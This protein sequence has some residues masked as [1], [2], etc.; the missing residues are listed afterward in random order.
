MTVDRYAAAEAAAERA[1]Q[2]RARRQPLLL[3]AL[4]NVLV[5]AVAATVVVDLRRLATPQGTG[6]AW[7]QAAVFGDCV[8]YLKLSEPDPA[9]PDRRT[10]QEICEDL[11]QATRTARTEVARIGLRPV[12]RDV[13]G[14]SAVVRVRLTRPEGDVTVQLDLRRSH[15]R[16]RVVRDATTCASVGCA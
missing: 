7:T 13:R 4:L 11:N 1:R 9:L 16:W 14:A 15:G 2:R 5:L 8:A 6:L 3:L 10:D 12:G